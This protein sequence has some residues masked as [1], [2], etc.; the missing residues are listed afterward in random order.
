MG[1]GIL[2]R[3]LAPLVLIFMIVGTA[4]GATTGTA[5]P[6]AFDQVKFKGVS[7]RE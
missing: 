7:F 5:V 1:L 3:F 6:E 2:D 4:V